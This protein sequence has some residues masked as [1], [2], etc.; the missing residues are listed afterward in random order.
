MC[1]TI[2]NKR[3]AALIKEVS[4]NRVSENWVSKVLRVVRF[5]GEVND[6]DH[7]TRNLLD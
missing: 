4:T 7:P 5:G 1:K 2:V 6:I 3:T